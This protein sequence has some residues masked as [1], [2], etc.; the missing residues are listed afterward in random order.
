MPR[1]TLYLAPHEVQ[2]FL[3]PTLARPTPLPELFQPLGHLHSPGLGLG[4]GSFPTGRKRRAQFGPASCKGD[5]QNTPLHS[6]GYG[7]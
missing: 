7:G 3:S 2:Q 1:S 5:P 4:L 6:S